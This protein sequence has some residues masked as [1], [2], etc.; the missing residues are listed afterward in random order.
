MTEINE[1]LVIK[2]YLDGISGNKI[3]ASLGIKTHQVYYVLKKNKIKS[4]SNSINSKR[5]RFN[6]NFFENIDN[7]RKAY[8]LGFLFADGYI[9]SKTDSFGLALSTKDILHMEKFLF[10]ISSN[11]K[12]SVYRNNS[13]KEYCRIRLYSKK[14]KEDLINAGCK[15]NKTLILD[16][17]EIRKDLLPHFIRGYFDGDGSISKTKSKKSPSFRFRL[18]GTKEFLRGVLNAIGVDSKLYQR[19]PERNVNNYDIDIGGNRQ[20]I[21]IL[22]FIYKDATVYLERKYNRFLE[23]KS[24]CQEIDN[25][26][27]CENGETL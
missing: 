5:Y 19:H 26:K 17:P 11:H 24:L 9:L 27:L 18:C 12:I 6:E 20:V 4:R 2:M 25:R 1:K 8:W 7:E 10:D 21:E 22:S 13:D 16:F 23:L 14:T 15:E 3:A